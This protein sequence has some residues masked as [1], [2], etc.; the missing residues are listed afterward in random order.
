MAIKIPKITWKPGKIKGTFKVIESKN[1]QLVREKTK[2][3][4]KITFGRTPEDIIPK[5]DNF[6]N[7]ALKTPVTEPTNIQAEDVRSNFSPEDQVIMDDFVDTVATLDD[8]LNKIN[9]A[10]DKEIDKISIS[11]DPTRTAFS[12]AHHCPRC[13]RPDAPPVITAED[14]QLKEKK[15]MK[16]QSAMGDIGLPKTDNKEEALKAQ[17]EGLAKMIADMSIQVAKQILIWVLEFIYNLVKWMYDIDIAGNK[18]LKQLPEDLKKAIEALKG[19]KNITEDELKRQIENDIKS[20]KPPSIS[21]TPDLNSLSSLYDVACQQHYNV[22][23]N[24]MNVMMQGHPQEPALAGKQANN[25]QIQANESRK[26]FGTAVVPKDYTTPNGNVWNSKSSYGIKARA[27]GKGIQPALLPGVTNS[28]KNALDGYVANMKSIINGWFESQQTL[29]CLIRNI[30][31]LSGVKLLNDKPIDLKFSTDTAETGMRI[32][33]DAKSFLTCMRELLS[34]NL[35][36][37]VMDLGNLILNLIITSLNKIITAYAAMVRNKVSN[38]AEKALDIEKL[39]GS[40]DTDS[41]AKCIPWEQFIDAFASAVKEFTLHLGEYL[42]SFLSG[43]ELVNDK[44]KEITIQMEYALK[45]QMWIE[46]ID[47]ILDF[48]V[49]WN[50]CIDP[51]NETVPSQNEPTMNR[52]G[53]VSSAQSIGGTNTSSLTPNIPTTDNEDIQNVQKGVTINN[54]EPISGLNNDIP[55]G[56]SRSITRASIFGTGTQSLNNNADLNAIQALLTNKFGL[57]PE[58]ANKVLNDTGDCG[59]DK[60]LSDAELASITEAFSK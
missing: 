20:D 31:R 58:D 1:D 12:D 21:T 48:M 26:E 18:P 23:K 52:D 47:K 29:C 41:I 17:E 5:K 14:I 15:N 22:F 51:A 38:W 37:K 59:C 57:T 40:A 32:L 53:S 43:L 60:V 44:S 10:L 46:T 25:A 34:L 33:K 36:A 56:K 54:G 11:Y 9:D 4:D 30:F 35:N 8:E 42:L 19:N 45:I 49:M 28:A 50:A 27:D 24:G 55:N 2:G 7:D 13:G 6:I 3:E 16:I 39:K